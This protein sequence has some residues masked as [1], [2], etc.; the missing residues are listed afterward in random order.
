MEGILP[1]LL[2]VAVLVLANAAFA[3]SEMAL[4]SLREGQ[5]RRLETLGDSG[6]V[7]A[8]LAREPNRFLATIQ[9]GITLAGFLASAAAAVSLAEPLEGPLGFLGEAARPVAIIVVTLLLAYVTLVFG[10]LAPKRVA[11]QRAERWGLL[12]ARPL[13]LLSG[14]TRPAVWI[15]SHST[16]LA[17]R[18]MGGDPKRQREE[19]SEEELRELVGGHRAFSPEQRAILFGAFEIGERTLAQVLRSR[20]D[21]V[22]LTAA[23]TAADALEVLVASGHSRAPVADGGD[24]DH[25]V[26][27]VHLRDVVG[28]GPAPVRERASAALFIPKSA[29]VLHTL[30]E[31][32]AAR[33]QLA[34]VVDEHG[35][36]AG[37]VTV[38]DL[39]E[40][41]VGEIYDETDRDVAGVEHEPDG[42]LVL[43]GSFPVHDLADLGV[44]L[45][46][47][48][49]A[50]VAGLVLVAL[51]RIPEG[52]G[53]T[54]AVDGWTATVLAVDHRAITRIRLSRRARPVPGGR[55]QP[56]TAVGES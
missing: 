25:V 30:R 55:H 4:V 31:M 27:V 29:Q 49:Y 1:Q 24:L 26:G 2:L 15:L 51:G 48:H 13:A 52:P 3:G 42:S 20:R 34:I 19:V 28:A 50:T 35:G 44:E 41:L 11:M 45:P 39:L 18:V 8:R 10:E 37:I 36:G 54:V 56:A 14:L 12:V 47:G 22:T 43:T 16:N 33:Q 17:V 5:L 32:Q 40:E 21:V 53:D 23:S 6:L 7:L 9:I 46:E 38:E